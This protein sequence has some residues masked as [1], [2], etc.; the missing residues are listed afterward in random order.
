MR[1]VQQTRSVVGRREKIRA[2]ISDADS[3]ANNI[4]HMSSNP[5]QMIDY[6]EQ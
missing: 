1:I 2:L 5:C 6:T 4:C 3:I